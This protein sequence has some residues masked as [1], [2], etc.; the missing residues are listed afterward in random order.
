MAMPAGPLSVAVIMTSSLLPGEV[1]ESMKRD[2][3][4]NREDILLLC[5]VKDLG[6]KVIKSLDG[7]KR[8]SGYVIT[9]LRGYVVE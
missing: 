4:I 8:S 2:S 7:S 3:M 5:I 1:Q 9:W 6:V